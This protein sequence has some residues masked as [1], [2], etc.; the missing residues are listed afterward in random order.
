MLLLTEGPHLFYCDPSSSVVKGEIPW[1]PSIRPEAK[2]FKH[3]LV[4]T[5][6]IYFLLFFKFL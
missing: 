2:D 3:F 4:H 5:V 1:T 6:R